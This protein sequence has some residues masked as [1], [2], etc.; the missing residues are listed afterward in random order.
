LEQL[1]ALNGLPSDPRVAP[2]KSIPW[3]C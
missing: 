2:P 1:D 3:S